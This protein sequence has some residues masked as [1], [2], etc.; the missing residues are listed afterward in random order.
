[1]NNHYVVATIKSWNI[2]AFTEIRES[3]PGIWHL[4]T[5]KDALSVEFLEKVNPKYI[6]FPHWSWIVPNSILSRWNCVC[7]HMADVPYGRG[8]SPLQNLISRGHK[9]TKIS[10]LK[11]VDELDAG[12]VYLK[13]DLSLH[14]TAQDIFKR[15][16]PIVIDIAREI[17]K[18]NP[19]PITQT[20]EIVLFKR[21]T[22]EMSVL[23]SEGE[24][25]DIYDH[26]RMLD[27]DTYPKALLTHGDFILE[28]DSAM[29]SNE[30]FVEAK[31]KIRKVQ[32]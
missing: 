22:P 17:A 12:P 21:R 23:P 13:R 9:D 1:M 2:D 3:L 29:I 14:G 6:F 18:T 19:I 27:A 11:M 26:I 8:G 20:G 25:N 10:A 5:E 7:F 30:G 4:V 28:F 16:A 15:V 32:Q 24:L 31:V